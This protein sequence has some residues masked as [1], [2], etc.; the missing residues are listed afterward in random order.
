M[1]STGDSQTKGLRV[2]NNGS[3]RLLRYSLFLRRMSYDGLL[4]FRVGL[5]RVSSLLTGYS[6]N[7]SFLRSGL[8]K[9]ENWKEFSQKFR[10]DEFPEEMPFRSEIRKELD[11]LNDYWAYLNILRRGHLSRNVYILVGTKSDIKNRILREFETLD[12]FTT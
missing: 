12:S 1:R 7:H 2:K 11:L 10:R 4:L 8:K 3:Q 9:N 5:G 6:K